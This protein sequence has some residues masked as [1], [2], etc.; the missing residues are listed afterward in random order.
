[1]RIL[2]AEDEERARQ[3][4][5][6]LVRSIDER[7][8]VVAETANGNDALA[9]IR[10]YRPHAVLTDIRMPAMSGLELIRAAHEENLHPHFAMVSAYAEFEYAREAMQLGVRHYILK[11]VTYDELESVLA[12]LAALPPDFL[13]AQERTDVHPLIVRVLS[14]IKYNYARHIVLE[15]LA[16]SMSVTPEYLSSLFSK[17]VGESFSQYL[18]KSRME[19]AKELLRQGKSL[20]ETASSVGFSDLQYFYRVFKKVVGVTPSL[21]KRECEHKK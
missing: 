9:G 17:E 5:S 10:R 4:L 18:Q 11:P 8:T 13:Y 7:Y 14:E 19:Q 1:M 20:N 16:E 15:R 3:G 2:I 6:R 12:Q 21:F